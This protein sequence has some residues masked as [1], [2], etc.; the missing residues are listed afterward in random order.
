MAGT[1]HRTATLEFTAEGPWIACRIVFA[2]PAH[3][4]LLLG[5]IAR[6][7]DTPRLMN[8]FK[9]LMKDVVRHMSA[10]ADLPEP[11]FGPG[12]GENVQ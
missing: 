8:Q 7:A 11:V 6:C 12:S 3:E 2:N 10:D 1:L 9:D 5:S 4:P